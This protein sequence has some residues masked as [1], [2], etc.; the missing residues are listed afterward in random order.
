MRQLPDASDP[1]GAFGAVLRPVVLQQLGANAAQEE[2]ATPS[3]SEDM[4]EGKSSS[5]GTEGT[6][7]ARRQ[8]SNRR[9]CRTEK[10]RGKALEASTWWD[11][12]EG[13][14][15][16][17]LQDCQEMLPL[18]DQKQHTQQLLLL[19]QSL[20]PS[21]L[22]PKPQ[23]LNFI[24]LYPG[25]PP[26]P[27]A[28][29]AGHLLW[30]EAETVEGL[31]LYIT[32]T[33]NGFCVSSL[34]H[35]AYSAI[36]A[37][38]GRC[39]PFSESAD[40]FLFDT[41]AELLCAYSPAF[42][43]G[44]EQA[45]SP[46]AHLFGG[47]AP[48]AAAVAAAHAG[49]RLWN[50][51]YAAVLEAL[52][53]RDFAQCIASEKQ[54]SKI[55]AEFREAAL[56]G[57]VALRERQLLPYG[58]RSM[59]SMKTTAGDALKGLP[60]AAVHQVY[61]HNNICLMA[62]SEL[63]G[64][65]C[66]IAEGTGRC[67]DAND[68]VREAMRKAAEAAEVA[69]LCEDVGLAA[70]AASSASAPAAFRGA[71]GVAVPSVQEFKAPGLMAVTVDYAGCRILCQSIHEDL[72]GVQSFYK[73]AAHEAEQESQSPC[74]TANTFATVGQIL[75]VK[76][77][78]NS[79]T[80]PPQSLRHFFPLDVAASRFGLGET[81]A[82]LA[83]AAAVA[84]ARHTA[85]ANGEPAVVAAVAATAAA[86][87]ELN[88]A[89][90]AA[91][92]AQGPSHATE[93]PEV[94]PELLRAFLLFRKRQLAHERLQQQE[95]HKTG[96]D[97]EVRAESAAAPNVPPTLEEELQLR[98]E[99]VWRSQCRT[100]TK[101]LL[102]AASWFG[103]DSRGGINGFS[104]R[105]VRLQELTNDCCTDTLLRCMERA[106]EQQEALLETRREEIDRL[107]TA[108]E[109]QLEQ[110]ERE[111]QHSTSTKQ[112]DTVQ[113]QQ[114]KLL[115]Q[116]NMTQQHQK[117][118]ETSKGNEE[119]TDAA[120]RPLDT[121]SVA[122][123]EIGEV[124]GTVPAGMATAALEG[125]AGDVAL[126][127]LLGEDVSLL[128]DCD[129]ATRAG[130]LAATAC[131]MAF[132]LPPGVPEANRLL[133]DAG[134]EALALDSELV[135]KADRES[136]LLLSAY[137][138]QVAV[139]L[140]AKLLCAHYP[141]SDLPLDSQGLKAFIHSCGLNC[142]HLGAIYRAIQAMN[143]ERAASLPEM[144]LERDII[145][146]C[147]KS[148]INRHL[149]TLTL[150][151][152][153]PAAAHLISCLFSAV[154]LSSPSQPAV[155]GSGTAMPNGAVALRGGP[156]RALGAVLEETPE[157]FWEAIRRRAWTRFGQLLPGT[158]LQC[159]TLSSVAGRFV[160]L[161]SLCAALGIQL[162]AEVIPRLYQQQQQKQ[163]VPKW[164][165]L[166][167]ANEQKLYMGDDTSE[168]SVVP[169]RQ[170][171][172]SV[173]E[174]QHH[175]EQVL[176]GGQCDSSSVSTNDFCSHLVKAE[177]ITRIAPVPK[178]A[179]PPSHVVRALLS[180]ASHCCVFGSFDA[181]L[182][183]LQQALCVAH[184]LSGATGH[185]LRS[186][187]FPSHGGRDYLVLPLISPSSYSA[188]HVKPTGLTYMKYVLSW[189]CADA[190]L[191]EA[192]TCYAAIGQLLGIVDD[193]LNA[194]NNLQKCLILMDRRAGPDHPITLDIHSALAHA[195]ARLPG[196]QYTTRG[197]RHMQRALLML[198]TWTAGLAHPMLPLLLLGA[199]R[200]LLQQY[201]QLQKQN[202]REQ[203]LES[204]VRCLRAAEAALD[205]LQGC[206]PEYCAEVYTE[207][208]WIY[209]SIGDW[210]KA[211]DW[212]R[213]ARG[214]FEK[215]TADIGVL[216]E[217]EARMVRLTRSLVMQTQQQKL[218]QYQRG[219]LVSRLRHA[220]GLMRANNRV[221]VSAL[222]PC[223]G[224][225]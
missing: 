64:C 101:E 123:S 215:T 126:L 142:R 38:D 130:S 201:Q 2:H 127:S 198:H 214:A 216:Q 140:A 91:G 45:L 113:Q 53:P 8:R 13:A 35:C 28:Q 168:G 85:R 165:V 46:E 145:L 108:L 128:Q 70:A 143:P 120:R 9:K 133:A 32:S 125:R 191:R 188:D 52:P 107:R 147:A 24:R 205:E 40:D 186:S 82:E 163:K 15:G 150:G 224:S 187:P 62:D 124:A 192:S 173:L 87:E 30:L 180:A 166:L 76:L 136:L 83:A 58:G 21:P 51:E 220:T 172:R 122:A 104:R 61:V 14:E 111:E 177:D 34:R 178:G 206:S 161:R 50:A 17:V 148:R 54:S 199:S 79:K 194:C 190:A 103:S 106:R 162:R 219:L 208:S 184:Q 158:P 174:G 6:P 202:E 100:T 170:Q 25:G 43:T 3:R 176:Q 31:R 88:A 112:K 204:A 116:D 96:G 4:A 221:D 22:Q 129:L 117:R 72:P 10:K 183:L 169:H 175:G 39:L 69:R 138:R 200:C 222:L 98:L 139:P 152:V 207:L 7:M 156:T 114:E 18:S 37:P 105:V 102:R 27:T 118:Q 42:A 185:P 68:A 95:E 196:N 74:C 33:E 92:F 80:S 218:Q 36:T 153:A 67:L 167:Q 1:C 86:T 93:C 49:H 26:T 5:T 12:A 75:G 149:S 29:L 81:P 144:L 119:G 59:P 157:S 11:V 63:F 109:R 154:V 223:A 77:P 209:E 137:L 212:A 110:R 189:L 89:A 44:Q 97:V 131:A 60:A 171:A 55:A 159:I 217:A 99:E 213:S 179:H 121:D 16:G 66:S 47:M 23:L 141:S 182:D 94:R 211:L 78:V 155:N 210:R 160:L 41:L 71:T 197:L 164:L 65:S 195:F 48:T 181:A 115:L 203:A 56:Q 225:S 193:P 73:V 90:A 84:A 20:L 134:T 57:A 135:S 132:P 146:R 151:E 19:Q